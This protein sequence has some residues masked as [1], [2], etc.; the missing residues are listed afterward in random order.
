MV[1]TSPSF[2]PRRAAVRAN[3]ATW[4]AQSYLRCLD[5]RWAFAPADGA[6]D[7]G[8]TFALNDAGSAWTS[9]LDPDFSTR[10]LSAFDAL[11]AG[12]ETEACVGPA[13]ALMQSVP[14]RDGGVFGGLCLTDALEQSPTPMASLAQLQ[15]RLPGPASTTWSV[16]GGFSPGCAVEAQDDGVH[17]A[18]VTASNGAKESICAPS[19]WASFTPLGF[20][21]CGARSQYFLGSRPTVTS[22]EVR[23][24]GVL[25][26]MTAWSYDAADNSVRFS[27]APPLGSTITVRYV[28]TCS[29]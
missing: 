15:A 28:P 14:P 16:V 26:P 10:A 3:L 23:V 21:T 18:L 6:P 7:A 24:D 20:P 5:L 29:P 27:S 1:D 22:L 2:A 8:V 25:V 17:G 9:T 19:W 11:P 12:S 13:A 4:L